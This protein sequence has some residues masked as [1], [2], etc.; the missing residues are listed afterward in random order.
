[1]VSE[2]NHPFP[3]EYACEGFG[4]FAAYAAFQD[5]DGVFFYTFEHKVPSE[6]T[7]KMPSHFEVRPDPVKMMNIAA[8]ACLFLRG[9]VQA[10]K[11]TIYRSYSPEQVRESIRLP[12]SERPFFTPG[13]DAVTALI[14]ATRVRSFN[15]SGGPYPHVEPSSTILSDTGQLAW[16]YGQKQQGFVTIETDR[17]QALIGFVPHADKPLKNLA[18]TIENEFCSLILTSLQDKTIAQADRLLLVATARAANTGMKW[19]DKRTSLTDWGA[20]PTLIEPVR[21]FVT[22]R[23][24]NTAGP[25]EVMPLDSGAKPLGKPI[26]AEKTADGSRFPIGESVTP[27]YLIRVAR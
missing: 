27:W 24:I 7:A 5:W 22:L 15:A 10:A 21:G 8:G 14:H 11:E 4:I 17:S 25:I 3:N 9:D 1:M 18:A 13:F 23:G 16:H 19:N 20:E 26:S 2:I 12:S 6:W